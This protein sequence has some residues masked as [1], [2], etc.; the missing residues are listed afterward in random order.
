[1]ANG[2][3]FGGIAQG[4]QAGQQLQLQRG[5]AQLQQQQFAAQQKAAQAKADQQEMTNNFALVKSLTGAGFADAAKS[6]FQNK[7]LPDFQGDGVL[8]DIDLETVDEK[9]MK[10]FSKLTDELEKTGDMNRFHQQLMAVSNVPAGK[11]DFLERQLEGAQGQLVQEDITQARGIRGLEGQLDP[12]TLSQLGGAEGLGAISQE[13]LSRTPEGQKVATSL[14]AGEVSAPKSIDAILAQRVLSGEMTLEE[15]QESKRTTTQKA[16]SE[17]ILPDGARVL[18]FDGGRTYTDASG[19][20]RPIPAGARKAAPTTATEL[21]VERDREAATSAL[22]SL[23]GFPNAKRLASAEESARG[24][25]GPYAKLFSAIDAVAGGLGLDRAFGF[26]EGFFPET[27]ENRQHLRLIKQTGKEGFLNSARGAIYEQKLIDELFPN[28]STMWANPE[29]EVKKFPLMRQR[30][31]QEIQ[32]NLETISQATDPKIISKLKG[33]TLALRKLLNQIGEEG[34]S[35]TQAVTTVN[36]PDG[37][38]Q[39]FDASGKRI[40]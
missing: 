15:A 13:L 26:K 18:S 25:T 17:F 33:S 38:T 22:A 8:G 36:M 29:T 1:M 3:L 14:R 2:N 24:G 39:T 5:Q 19:A 40:Q 30:A 20:T 16:A 28:P 11:Q 23:P 6:I 37:S 31:Q 27:Q 21:G 35:A 9:F 34:D 10:S 7:I 12:A 32:F 4:L